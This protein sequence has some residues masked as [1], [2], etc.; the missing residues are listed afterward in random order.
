MS[1]KIRRRN[2]SIPARI[3]RIKPNETTVALDIERLCQI[4]KY[5]KIGVATE[6]MTN[7][8][9]SFSKKTLTILGAFDYSYI[10]H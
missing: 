4:K 8:I 1:D 10:E 2:I 6:K 5:T 3:I 9:N 7:A